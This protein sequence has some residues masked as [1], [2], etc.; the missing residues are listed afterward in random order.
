MSR[1]AHAVVGALAAIHL[2]HV[3]AQRDLADGR[4]GRVFRQ[5]GLRIEIQAQ[6]GWQACHAGRQHHAAGHGTS[7]KT[8]QR[9]ILLDIARAPGRLT[10]THKK[11]QLRVMRAGKLV[12]L[13]GSRHFIQHLREIGRSTNGVG[14][15]LRFDHK[16]GIFNL[17]KR[18]GAVGQLNTCLKR[19]VAL[20]HSR[21]LPAARLFVQAFNGKRF[22]AHT[23]RSGHGRLSC[24]PINQTVQRDRCDHVNQ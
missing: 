24:L 12:Q 2:R 20:A 16:L 17:V 1:L 14:K 19:A 11:I 8:Q 22:A 18:T 7:H 23:P 15:R 6:D 5:C 9:R 21:C 4:L 13:A 10:G 3:Q